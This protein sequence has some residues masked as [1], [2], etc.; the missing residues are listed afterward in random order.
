[1]R[2]FKKSR[3]TSPL[4]I[5]LLMCACLPACGGGGG[6]SSGSSVVSG[7]GSGSGSGSEGTLGAGGSNAPTTP[8]SSPDTAQ[9]S[10]GTAEVGIADAV[11]TTRALGVSSTMALGLPDLPGAIAQVARSSGRVFHIDSVNGADANDGLSA[12]TNSSTGGSTSGPTSGPTSGS[13]GPWRTLARLQ[14]QTDL[15]GGDIVELACASTWHETLTLPADGGAGSPIIIAPPS[16]G[17]TV[18]PSIDGSVTLPASAWSAY[19]GHIYQATLAAT[20]LQMLAST[21]AMTVAHFPNSTD[22]AADP[23]SPYLALAADSSG[24]VLTTGADFVLPAG[25]T[26]DTTTRVHVRTNTYIIDESQVA[27]FDGVHL[28]LAKAPTY[29]VPGG[30]GYF[31]TG[32]LWMLRGAGQ[33]YYDASAQQLY[34]WMPDSAA[35]SAPV[36][37]ATLAV[38]IDL[39]GRNHV[40]IDGLRVHNV[41]LG[42]DLRSTTDIDVRNLRVEDTADVGI[43]AAGSSHD[44][45][46]ASRVA[47]TGGDAITGWGGAMNPLLPDSTAFT[48]RNN[49]VRESGVLMQ[50]DQV[51]SL[52]RRSMAAIFIGNAS[53]ATGNVIV[54][55]GYIGILAEIGNVVSDNFVYGACSVQ[56]DCGGIYTNGAYNRSQITGN[57][58]MH[59]RGFL[60]GQP[61]T[62]RSTAAQGIYL[63]DYGSDMLVQSNTV[64]DADY[65]LQL[66]NA[67]RNVV[68]SNRLYANRRGQIWMQEDHHDQN[69]NGDVNANTIDGNEL[70]PV[71]ASAVGM[72]LTTS[73]ASTSAFGT[74][75]SN[76]FY[77]RAS[78]AAVAVSTST[79]HQA[80]TFGSWRGSTGAGSTQ[81]VDLQGA[82]TSTS[83]YTAYRI[84]GTNL[85]ANSA[86]TTDTAGWSNWNQTAPAG[87][88]IRETCPAG[89]CLRYVAGGSS[90]IL[91]SP[92]FAV[93]QGQWYRLSVD[94]WTQTDN[95]TV[96][97]IVRIGSGSYA[98]VA[99]RNLNFKGSTTWTRHSVVFQATQTVAAGGARVDIDG[100]VAGQSVS[101]ANLELVPI[102]P[103]TLAMT[104]G[105]IVNG[106]ATASSATCPFATSQPALCGQLFDL[107]TD[108]PVTWPLSVPALGASILYAREPALID[109]DGDGIPDDQDHCPNSTPG[110]P[111]DA[112]GCELKAS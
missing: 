37:I 61:L 4:W 48:V 22:V 20:P 43:D 108:A 45:V 10:S 39:K 24:A 78:P 82:A 28:T 84:A 70:A 102:T 57:T 75:T 62:N 44:V 67:A 69:P 58:V 49:V 94:T 65:G 14:Q 64:I 91:T 31:L 88:A 111:V 107:A 104:S 1:M 51:A 52:P 13:T 71:S 33:W 72:L 96:P 81:P 29:T 66:H 42:V 77:D 50:G 6:G 110:V 92:S 34:T 16:A 23:G 9:G 2:S 47:R 11:A 30:W 101:L 79:S 15:R 63:D 95:Q 53:S 89:T 98:S 59:S 21:G 73:Y 17:C 7:S 85:V 74:F 60:F 18:A 54:D 36:N 35:P 86:L 97:L 46:E 105:V 32:Q 106:S 83:G 112:A 27:A 100:I 40:V 41:G 99:D 38:G 5:A 76:R 19:H 90:G 87:Q 8:A 25:A 26:I 3:S 12:S 109:S 56:D 55:A 93:A 80:F 68:R 103:D